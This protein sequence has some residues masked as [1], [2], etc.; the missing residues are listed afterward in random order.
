MVNRM[1]T[2]LWLNGA[3]KLEFSPI[4]ALDDGKFGDIVVSELSVLVDC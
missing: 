3:V 1:S 2:G 4:S